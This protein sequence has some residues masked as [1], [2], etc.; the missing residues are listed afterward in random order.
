[1][2]KIR[3]ND[4]EAT[5]EMVSPVREPRGLHIVLEDNR[6]FAEIAKDFEGHDRLEMTNDLYD[7]VTIY[8]GYTRITSMYRRGDSL[9]LVLAKEG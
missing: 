7:G 2:T 1:M 8:E 6:P 9:T 5:V 3:A 4:F